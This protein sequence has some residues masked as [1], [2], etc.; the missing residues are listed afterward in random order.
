MKKITCM[1][2]MAAMLLMAIPAQAQF[3]E[4]M[5]IDMRELLRRHTWKT[6]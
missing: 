5:P 3:T 4:K 6:I 2:I 1:A